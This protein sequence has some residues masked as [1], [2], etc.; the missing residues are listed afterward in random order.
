[1]IHVKIMH[2]NTKV[3]NSPTTM[4]HM[5]LYLLDFDRTPVICLLPAHV[6]KQERYGPQT[7]YSTMSD[8]VEKLPPWPPENFVDE[9]KPPTKA[10]LCFKN[11]MPYKVVRLKEKLPDKDGNPQ[12]DRI[13]L[14]FCHFDATDQVGK[15]C[16]VE[17]VPKFLMGV[18]ETILFHVDTWKLLGMHRQFHHTSGILLHCLP[19]MS[20]DKTGIFVVTEIFLYPGNTIDGEIRTKQKCLVCADPGI[21]ACRCESVYFCCKSHQGLARTSGM[22]KDVECDVLSFKLTQ[23]DL[24]RARQRMILMH[25][26]ATEEKKAQEQKAAE[27]D[28]RLKREE[29]EKEDMALK[30]VAILNAESAAKK[31]RLQVESVKASLALGED[32]DP[33]ID[34]A[35]VE[36]V[37]SQTTIEQR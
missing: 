25:D 4:R 2:K 14:Y 18:A 10:T 29:E 21:V 37:L 6:G 36:E 30:K 17:Y 1:M 11:Q 26:L 12:P 27:Q 28:R 33:T 20:P 3:K 35:I 13:G 19:H 15:P 5:S 32:P 24:V 34:P 7:V 31:H 9:F 23:F 16:W 8:E 22:H